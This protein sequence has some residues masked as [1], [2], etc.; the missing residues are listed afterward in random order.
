MAIDL[1]LDKIMKMPMS[2]RILIL[3]LIYLFFIVAFYMLIYNPKNLE[4]NS[5]NVRLEGLKK[6]V[7]ENRVIAANIPKFKR[8]KEEL[9]VQ[10]KK[11]LA[12]L[13]NKKE[14]PNLINNISMAGKESGLDILIFKPMGEKKKDFYAEVP[15]NMRV[16]SGFES[17]YAFCQKVGS[18]SRIV[19][20][21]GLN[22][23]SSKDKQGDIVLTSN[24]MATTFR[25]ISEGDRKAEKGQKGRR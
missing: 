25:F 8:E 7:A 12:Q 18:M 15:V 23:S 20:I 17:L 6:K 1:K 9:E 4:T 10:L 14:I 22:I 2:R 5:L 3:V 16:S 24:F 13:P 19:N 11:A 21:G